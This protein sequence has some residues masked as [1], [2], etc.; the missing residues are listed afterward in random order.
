MQL[1][2]FYDQ[3]DPEDIQNLTIYRSSAGSGKTFT[4]VKDYLKLVLRDPDNYRKIL[5]ITFTNK[6]SEEMKNRILEELSIISGDKESQLRSLIE[7]EFKDEGISLQ[8]VSRATI[9]LTKILHNYGKFGVSTLDHFFAKVV[10]AFA[11]ELD[12]PLAYDLDVD[13]TRAI[14]FAVERLYEDLE[15]D[16]SLKKWLE[17]F[18]FSKMEAD[19]GWDIDRNLKELGKELFAENFRKGI[20]ERKVSLSEFEKFVDQ[21]QNDRKDF[22]SELFK[23]ARQALKLIEEHG[24]EVKDFAYGYRGFANTFNKILKIDF[25]FN[26]TFIE[27][28]SGE[29]EWFAKS[30]PDIEAINRVKENG[31]LDVCEKILFYHHNNIRTYNTANNLLKNIYSYG[32]LGY[33]DDKLKE[34]R[35]ENNV[36]LLSDH[37]FLLNEV[38]D[39][40]DAPIVYEKIGSRFKHILID[41]FQDTSLFQW[42]NILPLVQN[43]LESFGNVLIV[44]D[45]KQSIYRWRGGDMK[46]LISGIQKDLVNFSNQT[47]EK[48]LDKN[49]RSAKNIVEFNNSFF[50]TA[51]QLIEEDP[52]LPEGATLIPDTYKHVEQKTTIEEEGRVNIEFLMSD[53]EDWKEQAKNKALQVIK[54]NLQNGYAASDIMILVD[55]WDL[56]YEMA[57]FLILNGFDVITDKSLKVMNNQMVQLLINAIK[58]LH[59]DQ[60]SL[61]KTNLLFIYLQFQGKNQYEYH[62]IFTD[63]HQKDKLFLAEMPSLFIENLKVFLRLPLYELVENLIQ[64]FGMDTQ[65]NNFVLRFQEICLEQSSKGNNDLHYFLSWWE[66]SKKDLVVITPENDRAIEIM[67]V[68][69]AKGLQKPIVIIPFAIYDVGTKFGSLFWSTVLE[70]EYQKF[71]ILPLV[72]EKKLKDSNLEDAYREEYMGGI[73]ERLNMTYVAFTRAEQQLYI[74]AEGVKK[75]PQDNGKINKLMFR[76]FDSNSFQYKE[77]WNLEEQC[78]IWGEKNLKPWKSKDRQEIE[79]LTILEKKHKTSI[80]IRSESSRF[81]M[82][83]DNEKSDKIK[84][85]LL[86]HYL[87]EQLREKSDVA[88][89]IRNMNNEGLISSDK[90][91]LLQEEADKLLGLSKMQSWFDGSWEVINERNIVTPEGNIRPD[92]VMIKGSEVVILDYK[93]G[94]KSDSHK[95]Q[96]RRYRTAMEKMGYKNVQT[97]LI[98]FSTSEIEEAA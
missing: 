98:Y 67:T 84:N 73:L 27:S 21:L 41:E 66:E 59:D 65:L 34:Y 42:K 36:L 10:R 91:I 50:R 87:F 26:K 30:S 16:K 94:A 71:N 52:D 56:G 25:E 11:K 88:N 69:K 78:F 63:I 1:P 92:R 7:D 9:A 38:I 43:V 45:V 55:K 46:L 51:V 85:G 32:I 54:D 89:G 96:M 80:A 64:T 3:E 4:L 40:K 90:G 39:R 81:F 5:A 20:G 22:E 79:E 83:F 76:V 31:L 44:G 82:L 24:L 72:F 37:A 58:W 2:L 70:E 15:K 35:I 95:T 8:I 60:D 6:A 47:I 13:E 74:Y 33:I 48:Q 12:L 28:I 97:F 19:K 23:Y 53:D 77:Y 18:A 68:H 29:K 14:E 86:L 93:T 61:A 17:D 62:Q 57:D 49:F 75:T